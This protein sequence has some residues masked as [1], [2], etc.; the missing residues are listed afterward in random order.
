MAS[1]QIAG[2]GGLIIALAPAIIEGW[3]M[4]PDD[5]KALLPQGPSRWLSVGVLVL[6]VAGRLK[7]Q[8]PSDK[9]EDQK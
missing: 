2:I 8:I 1:V 4:M 9:Q 5:L 3:G 7:K 6:V